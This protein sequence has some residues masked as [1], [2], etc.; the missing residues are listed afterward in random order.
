MHS[1]PCS[2]RWPS[3]FIALPILG[4]NI[5]ANYFSSSQINNSDQTITN[6]WWPRGPS[7]MTYFSNKGKLIAGC[8]QGSHK[9]DSSFIMFQE[10]GKGGLGY[11]EMR[12]CRS[13]QHIFLECSCLL[14]MGEQNKTTSRWDYMGWHNPE[15]LLWDKELAEPSNKTCSSERCCLPLGVLDWEPLIEL[16]TWDKHM[17]LSYQ[18]LDSLISLRQDPYQSQPADTS[19]CWASLLSGF[20]LGFCIWIEVYISSCFNAFISTF[21]PFIWSLVYSRTRETQSLF[22]VHDL[23]LC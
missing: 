9:L 11:S 10:E 13:G 18:A 14:E 16:S 20:L 23:T 22:S 3:V 15:G 4:E 1:G 6:G 5:Q 2:S 12:G 7:K 19:S 17:Q 21:T 8:R